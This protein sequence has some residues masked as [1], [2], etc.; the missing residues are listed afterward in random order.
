M[1]VCMVVGGL[2]LCSVLNLRAEVACY[3]TYLQLRRGKKFGKIFEKIPERLVRTLYFCCWRNAN[4]GLTFAVIK[5]K[6]ISTRNVHACVCVCVDDD[7]E[8]IYRY[9]PCHN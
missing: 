3:A 4:H 2:S 5:P 9:N 6:Y 8:P 1:Y 7:D